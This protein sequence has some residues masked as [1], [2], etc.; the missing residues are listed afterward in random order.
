MGTVRQDSQFESDTLW[1][2]QPVNRARAYNNYALI[3]RFW[4]WAV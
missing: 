1:Y 2:V 4:W 3:F